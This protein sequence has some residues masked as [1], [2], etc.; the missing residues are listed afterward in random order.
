MGAAPA[1]RG[2][3]GSDSKEQEPEGQ[4]ESVEEGR[5]GLCRLHAGAQTDP[6]EEGGGESS[7]N[8][9]PWRREATESCPRCVSTVRVHSCDCTTCTANKRN[10]DFVNS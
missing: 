10:L 8:G 7:L 5:R 3:Q 2:E 4:E 1:G 6:G 9:P